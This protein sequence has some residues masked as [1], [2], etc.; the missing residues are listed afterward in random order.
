V[1]AAHLKETSLYHLSAAC[2][3]ANAEEFS[4]RFIARD[5][6]VRQ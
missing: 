1:D 5:R 4:R 2:G 3:I 6:E